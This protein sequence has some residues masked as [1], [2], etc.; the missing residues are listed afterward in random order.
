MAGLG[1]PA[2]AAPGRPTAAAASLAQPQ[3]GAP[4]DADEDEGEPASPEEQAMYEAFVDKALGVI[5][6]PNATGQVSP[7][8]LANLKGD[9]DTQI[10]SMFEPAEPALTDSPADTVAA[11]ATL[12]TIMVQGSIGQPVPEDVVMHAGKA[13][14]EEMVEVAE[15]AGLKDFTEEQMEGVFYRAID[16]YRVAS[17]F[18]DQEAL[19]AEFGKIVEADKAGQLGAVLPGLPGGAPMPQGD[20]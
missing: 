3:P 18:V 7:E 19:K 5:Y 10:L 4:M 20:A 8:I 11:V 6:S 13:I 12:L 16:L 17:P 14:V 1:V 9:F 2:Q 15:A